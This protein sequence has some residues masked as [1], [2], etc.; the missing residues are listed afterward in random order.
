VGQALVALNAVKVPGRDHV[1][2]FHDHGRDG[3]RGNPLFVDAS[4]ERRVWQR[5]GHCIVQI[6]VYLVDCTLVKQR[7]NSTCA[8]ETLGF[9]SI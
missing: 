2:F 7:S 1:F 9:T 5:A 8:D 3:T 4:I 6:S